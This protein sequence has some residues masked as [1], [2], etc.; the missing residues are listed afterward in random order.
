M[1]PRRYAVL[2]L[3][4]LA[5]LSV[6]LLALALPAPV[7]APALP[8]PASTN[9]ALAALPAGLAQLASALNF[10]DALGLGLMAVAVVLLWSLA[11]VWERRGRR[12]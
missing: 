1:L 3:L 11:L 2:S 10:A 7:E 9:A 4:A 12:R 5:L 8:H 6:G